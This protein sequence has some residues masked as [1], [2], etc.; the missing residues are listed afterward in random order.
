MSTS[1][2]RHHIIYSCSKGEKKEKATNIL[3]FQ[4]KDYKYVETRFV[5]I[6]VIKGRAAA[7]STLLLPNHIRFFLSPASHS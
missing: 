5:R 1:V 4:E 6:K 3:I 7:K 2:K